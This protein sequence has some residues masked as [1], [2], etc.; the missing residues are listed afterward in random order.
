MSRKLSPV[1]KKMM[2]LLPFFHV[3]F[4]TIVPVNNYVLLYQSFSVTTQAFFL[5][6][7]EANVL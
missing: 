6:V 3:I 4:K 7:V 1:P 2:F 5:G